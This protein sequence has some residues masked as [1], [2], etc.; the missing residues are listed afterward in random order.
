MANTIKKLTI[1][2][3]K[4]IRKLDNFELR[5]L[6]VLIGAN[7]AGKSNFIG[8]FRLLREMVDQRLQVAL[9]TVEGGADACL[10]LGPKITQ[11]FVGKLYFGHNEYEFA[12]APTPDNRFV[13][14]KEAAAYYGSFIYRP[15][16]GSG[17]F[18]AKLVDHKDEVG[19][20]GT[21]R[22][23]PG[24]VFEAVSSW[25]VYHFHDTSLNAAVRRPRALNDN[26]SLRQNAENLAPFLY[27]IQRTSPGSYSKI[28][29]VVR[30]AAPFFDDFKLR[31]MPASPDMIQLEWQQKGS[32]YPFRAN[33]LSDG[34]LRFICLATALL[35]PV[36]PPTVLFDEPELGLHP[37]ALTLLGNLFKQAAE[38]YGDA[39]SKQVIISTQSAP[40]INEFEPEDIVVVERMNG[41]S[42]FRRLDSAQLSEWLDEYTLGELWQKNL[43][44]GR[45]REDRLLESMP[46]GE[47][48]Q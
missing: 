43:L 5:P 26:E 10:Y 11:Q 34:T 32:D 4:S 48:P 20:S 47:S 38:S 31:P 41:E 30:L 46:G 29:D 9:A 36:R 23:V 17:H 37:Y 35:Q 13:F 27:R 16:F 33:Q 42:I 12:L 44:G 21:K 39:I 15:S 7:G 22:G 2:G 8:F 19:K 25:V 40:L 24:H 3:F 14:L 18:E 45:P 1:E 6:N 28:R